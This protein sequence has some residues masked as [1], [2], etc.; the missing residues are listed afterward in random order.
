MRHPLADTLR[1]T[2]VAERTFGLLLKGVQTHISLWSAAVV[3]SSIP[4]LCSAAHFEPD[5][6]VAVECR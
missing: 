4:A 3:Q 6:T 5:C 1:L 2:D